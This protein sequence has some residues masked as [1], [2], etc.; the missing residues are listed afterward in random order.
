MQN[1]DIIG[2]TAAHDIRIDKDGTW[3][4]RGA[5]MIRKDI[6]NLFYRHIKRD[7]EGRYLIEYENARYYLDV[8]DTPYVIKS[9]YFSPADKKGKDVFDLLMPDDSIEKL[10]PSTLRAGYDN[11]LYCTIARLGTD[12]RFSRASYYQLARYI[13]HDPDK[14]LYYISL[15]GN[16]YAI[17]RIDN[18]CP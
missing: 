12:A 14:N 18:N 5:E 17:G 16:R 4:Y 10:D 7:T 6:V 1:I 3:Y 9:A 13:E 11:A 15:N 2:D 8:E